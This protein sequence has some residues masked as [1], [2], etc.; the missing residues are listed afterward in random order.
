MSLDISTNRQE[1]EELRK[2]HREQQDMQ[3]Q[4]M[5]NILKN[6][7]KVENKI[8]EEQ[9]SK[10]LLTEKKIKIKT[11]DHEVRVEIESP[12][13][14]PKD[15]SSGHLEKTPFS[16]IQGGHN[17]SSEAAGTEIP[18]LVTKVVKSSISSS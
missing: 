2:K 18:H 14:V 1:S 17:F 7:S 9:T 10:N 13:K 11:E 3:V 12:S 16:L 6:Q 5:M 4:L 8:L 15:R